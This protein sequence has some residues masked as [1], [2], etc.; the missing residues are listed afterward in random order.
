M[1]MLKLYAVLS[2]L[3]M[4]SIQSMDESFKAF[5]KDLPEEVYSEYLNTFLRARND[6]PHADEKK[7]LL[8]IEE[9][10]KLQQQLKEA[11]EEIASIRDAFKL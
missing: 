6:G 7:I 5:V 3:S 10:Q 4:V 9:K 2:L 1:K 11:Q 8:L